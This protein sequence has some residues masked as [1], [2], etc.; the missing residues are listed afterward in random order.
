MLCSPFSCFVYHY[1]NTQ[2]GRTIGHNQWSWAME[3]RD[4]RIEQMRA[5]KRD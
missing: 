5:L 4:D 1:T 3:R 2:R